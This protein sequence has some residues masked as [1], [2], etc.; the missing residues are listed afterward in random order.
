MKE[1]NISEL[2]FLQNLFGFRKCNHHATLLLYFFTFN[3]IIYVYNENWEETTLIYKMFYIMTD[4]NINDLKINA[5]LRFISIQNC[6]T[7]RHD[8]APILVP[9]RFTIK[10]R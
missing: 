1:T 2:H 7:I 10:T 4:K 9:T 5:E 6:K 8:I 3:L